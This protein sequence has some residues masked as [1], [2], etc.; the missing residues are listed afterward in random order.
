MK[1]ASV[2]LRFH[3]RSKD[4]IKFSLL[5]K[6]IKEKK[7]RQIQIIEMNLRNLLRCGELS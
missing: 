6:I 4:S 3:H 1:Q 5:G 7:E 2:K